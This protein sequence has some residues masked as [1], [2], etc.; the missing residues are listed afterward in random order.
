MRVI[1]CVV[2]A[3]TTADHLL[4]VD[5]SIWLRISM[6]SYSESFHEDIS[7]FRAALHVHNDTSPP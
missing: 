6:G 3:A 4:L 5:Y 7:I 1:A 2:I